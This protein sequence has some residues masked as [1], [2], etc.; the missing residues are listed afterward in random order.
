MTVISAFPYDSC[1]FESV[2]NLVSRDCACTKCI[3]ASCALQMHAI[4]GGLQGR[5]ISVHVIFRKRSHSSDLSLL[6]TGQVLY[7]KTSLVSL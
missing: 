5:M 4:D 1:G 7:C 6:M 2:L 3:L